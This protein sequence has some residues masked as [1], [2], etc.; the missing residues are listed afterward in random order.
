[1]ML[2][3]LFFSIIKLFHHFESKCF[4]EGGNPVYVNKSTSYFRIQSGAHRGE[5]I[6]EYSEFLQESQSTRPAP[7]CISPV[8]LECLCYP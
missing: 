7:C 6:H 4:I 2:K 1:M 3:Y 5:G 8:F